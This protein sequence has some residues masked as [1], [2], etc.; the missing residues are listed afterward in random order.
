VATFLYQIRFKKKF[1]EKKR[2][3]SYA[4]SWPPHCATHVP[5]DTKLRQAEQ[6]AAVGPRQTALGAHCALHSRQT[7]LLSA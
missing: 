2:T 4:Y 1:D 3:Q 5:R 7:R 6:L